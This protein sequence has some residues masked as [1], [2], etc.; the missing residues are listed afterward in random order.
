MF[1]IGARVVLLDRPVL[2]PRRLA[3]NQAIVD[4][5]SVA[6]ERWERYQAEP[7]PINPEEES[8]PADPGPMPPAVYEVP[9]PRHKPGIV[10][11]FEGYP[12]YVDEPDGSRTW[13]G[14]PTRY[15]LRLDRTPGE[16]SADIEDVVAA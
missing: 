13:V 8:E 1:E 16:H 14:E 12:N 2:G 10:I 11:G 3:A 9:E 15:V 5:W 4:G 6:V 7:W